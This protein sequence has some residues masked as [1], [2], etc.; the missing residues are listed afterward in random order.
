MLFRSGRP[1]PEWLEKRIDLSLDAIETPTAGLLSTL[2]CDGV[3]YLVVMASEPRTPTERID[4]ASVVY[5]N[6][7][8]SILRL[9]ET[10]NSKP[11][12]AS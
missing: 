1:Y 3:T 5:S 6:D 12:S 4:G 11:C 7:E 10:T 9:K 2:R 8:I